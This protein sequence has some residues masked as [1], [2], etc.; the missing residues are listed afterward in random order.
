MTEIGGS[1]VLVV[2]DEPEVRKLLC[3]V[4]RRC[5]YE[6]WAAGS[7]LH[8]LHFQQIRLI[9]LLI[10]DV[11]LPGMSGPVLAEQFATVQPGLKVLYISGYERSRIVQQYVLEEGRPLLTKPFD[12]AELEARVRDLLKPA[13]KCAVCGV[14]S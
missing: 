12:V 13:V 14:Q 2:D 6:V 9:D 8:A 11:V 4:I 3:A 10:T 1:I 5:G 7:G